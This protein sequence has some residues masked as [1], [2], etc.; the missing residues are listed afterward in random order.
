MLLEDVAVA[1]IFTWEGMKSVTPV[2]LICI[3][4]IWKAIANVWMDFILIRIAQT[5]ASRTVLM[6]LFSTLLLRTVLAILVLLIAQFVQKGKCLTLRT[7]S[8]AFQTV[9]GDI[10]TIRKSVTV[11]AIPSSTIVRETV[12]MV[13]ISTLLRRTVL[14]ILLLLIAQLVQMGKCLTLRTPSD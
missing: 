14:A 9:A 4:L 1:R 10:I 12:L 7:L 8:D 13:F 6:V 2:R 5:F 3:I 11:C